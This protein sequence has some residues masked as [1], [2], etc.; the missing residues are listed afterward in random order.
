ME[1]VEKIV[2]VDAPLSRVYNQ[3]TQ[4][5]DFPLFMPG[6]KAVSQIDDTHV[7]WSAEIMGKDLEWDAE[8]TEQQPDKRISWRSISGKGNAGTVRFEPMGQNR[9]RVRLVMAYEPEGAI[10]NVGDSLGIL[11]AQVQ[12]AVSGFKEFIESHGSET[13]AW[14]GQVHDSESLDG[15]SPT[16]DGAAEAQGVD[17]TPAVGRDPWQQ[18]AESSTVGGRP[19]SSPPVTRQTH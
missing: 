6:V 8:I 19:N 1:S 11:N 7:H 4:F 18:G 9:T 5:E 12:R 16:L 13:G 17:T 14:R 3:W 2:D 10:E 15:S